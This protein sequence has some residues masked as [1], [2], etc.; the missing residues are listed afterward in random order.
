M[1]ALREAAQQALDAIESD[2]MLFSAWTGKMIAARTALRA[3]LAQQAEP[4]EEGK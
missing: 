4:V 1:T 3:A 2:T